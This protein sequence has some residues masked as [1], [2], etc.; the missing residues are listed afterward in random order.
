MW[1]WYNIAFL[2]FGGLV[3]GRVGFPGGVACGVAFSVV[4]CLVWWVGFVV[5]FDVVGW[6]CWFWCFVGGLRLCGV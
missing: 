2:W 3:C 6:L 1:G 4:G 5:G